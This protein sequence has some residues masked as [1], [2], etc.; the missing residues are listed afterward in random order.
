MLGEKDRVRE[1][2]SFEKE[3][4]GESQTILTLGLVLPSI[5]PPVL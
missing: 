1:R 3:N 4:R 5:T 2:L